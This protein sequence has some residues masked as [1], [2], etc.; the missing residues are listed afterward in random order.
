M[1]LLV[2]AIPINNLNIFGIDDGILAK[3]SVCFPRDDST[4]VDE[5]STEETAQVHYAIVGFS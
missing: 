3:K 5:L 1:V 2:D 4:A